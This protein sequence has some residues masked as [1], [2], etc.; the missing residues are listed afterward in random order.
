MG[1][2]GWRHVDKNCKTL[3]ERVWPARVWLREFI[4]NAD[5]C[6]LN[7]HNFRNISCSLE[8][9]QTANTVLVPVQ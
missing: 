1:H 4:L 2:F 3:V 7:A 5:Y 9:L 8:F 6:Q